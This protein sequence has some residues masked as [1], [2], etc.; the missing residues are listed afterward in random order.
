MSNSIPK[1]ALIAKISELRLRIV[2]ADKRHEEHTLTDSD[3]ELELKRVSA[4]VD[5]L[6]RLVHK[7]KTIAA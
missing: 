3:Y 6:E 4:E 1:T 2:T 5:E 7:S